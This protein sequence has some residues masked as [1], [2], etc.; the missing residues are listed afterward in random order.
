[1]LDWLDQTSSVGTA[2][3]YPEDS[4][5]SQCITRMGHLSSIS[6]SLEKN[7]HPADPTKSAKARHPARTLKYFVNAFDFIIVVINAQCPYA[8]TQNA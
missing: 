3:T 8:M 4:T 6:A 2:V 1:M 7:T 5:F